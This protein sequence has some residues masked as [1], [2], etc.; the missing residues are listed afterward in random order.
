[1]CLIKKTKMKTALT[2]FLALSS[3]SL[4]MLASCKK[5]DPVITSN[6]GK[7]GALT[8]NATTIP[9]DKAKLND[10]TKVV[11]FT[12]SKP[13]FGYTAAI[14]NT[15]QIDVAGDNWAKPMSVTLGNSTLSQGYTT[16]AFNALLLKLNLAAGVASHIN[17]RI[18]HSVGVGAAPVYSNV[19]SLTVTPFNLASWVYVPG[20]YEGST[21]PNPGPLEDS[22]YSAT[23]NGV[24]VGI[25]NFT[26]GNNQ[27]LIVPVKN[28]NNKWATTDPNGTTSSTVTYNG[29][30]NFYAPATAGQYW[31]TFNTN[32]NTISFAPATYY[33]IIG[34]AAQ[35]WG[36]DVD[37]KYINDGSQTWVATLPMTQQAAPDNGFKIRKNHDWGTAYGTIATPDGK[38]LTSS[39]GVN[40]GVAAAGTYKITFWLNPADNTSTTAFY[41]Q[42][43]Q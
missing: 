2:K 28:W 7:A 27:F 39:N 31:V 21:W 8:A 34:N 35:G 18:E 38:S 32:N 14:T 4:L 6:G 24:Y 22:L 29:P 40:I 12:F 9:L 26:A 42:V 19:L 36:T 30:N 13:S 10:T 1:V 11:N 15:L 16:A 17:V 23:G 25:I 43:K 41:T 5:N 37:L 3:I 20:A 33:S